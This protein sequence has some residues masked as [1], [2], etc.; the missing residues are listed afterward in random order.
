MF[1]TSSNKTRFDNS[2]EKLLKNV[3]QNKFILFFGA[4]TLSE[5]EKLGEKNVQSA[6]CYLTSKSFKP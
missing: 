2:L 5:L 6:I 1:S 3:S 4:H